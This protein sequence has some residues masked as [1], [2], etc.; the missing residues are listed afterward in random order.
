M[1]RSQERDPTNMINIHFYSLHPQVI[2]LVEKLQAWVTGNLT[3]NVNCE[4][5]TPALATLNR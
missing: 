2:S 4:A 5:Q 1:R 3:R